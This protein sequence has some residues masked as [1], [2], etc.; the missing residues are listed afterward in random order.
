MAAQSPPLN[1]EELQRLRI[2]DGVGL[3]YFEFGMD[4]L[5]DKD[6]SKL[7]KIM[8]KSLAG[9][10][11]TPAAVTRE[12]LRAWL[13]GRGKPPVWKS[14]VDT[15]W[16][17]RF[18]VYAKKVAD[19]VATATQTPPLN[20]EELLRLDIPNNVA[21]YYETF[22]LH[23]LHDQDGSK[24]DAIQSKFATDKPSSVITEE[25][26]QAWLSGSGKP[27]SWKSL[28]IT[29]RTCGLTVHA[30][31]L[32]DHLATA[33]QTPPLN[34]EELLQL[35]IPK[36]VGSQYIMFGTQLL[37]DHDGTKVDT[38]MNTFPTRKSPSAI[39][40]EILQEWLG[41][42]GKPPTWKSLIDTLK[43]YSLYVLAERTED[44]IAKQ[45]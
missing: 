1:L 38:I 37:Q 13:S 35:K 14:L 6:G 31:E 44:H 3:D 5:L 12:I 4:L 26:L 18:T 29:L 21:R 33:A 11:M 39:T 9:T 24:I 30:K 34:L 40:R 42:C 32:E 8:N 25:I 16:T 43:K 41:G 17:C 20:L 23:L 22:G 2:P 10:P 45:Q 19:Y 27:L 28:V 15:L 7:D 36:W